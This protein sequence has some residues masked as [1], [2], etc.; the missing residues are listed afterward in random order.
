MKVY[1]DT[2]V[3]LRVLL[4]QE[5]VIEGWGQWEEAYSSEL[6][7]LEARRVIDRLRLE[8]RFADEAVAELNEALRSIEESLGLVLLTP[9]ILRRAAMPMATVVRTLD[10]VH[11]ATALALQEHRQTALVFATHD[12]QQAVGARALGLHCMG[13]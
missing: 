7:S 1:L 10:A 6:L 4:K 13:T 5:G 2:S 12:Q 3:I 11:V 8:G 9:A